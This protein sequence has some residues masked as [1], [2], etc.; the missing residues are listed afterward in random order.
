[1]SGVQAIGPTNTSATNMFL[2]A[3]AG[4]VTQPFNEVDITYV[5]SG[6]GE[7]EAETLTF[8]QDSIPH[9]VLTLTYDSSS[10]ITNITAS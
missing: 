1:M 5:A 3:I 6:N 8:S 4:L 7:G 2:E 9:T 10:R